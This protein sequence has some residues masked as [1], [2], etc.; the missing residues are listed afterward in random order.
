MNTEVTSLSPGNTTGQIPGTNTLLLGPTGVGKTYALRTA[1]A[2]GLEVFVLSTEPGI[3][4]TLGDIPSDK[5]HWKYVAPADTSWEDLIDSAQKINQLSFEALAKMSAI[6]KQ[7]YTQWIE[8]MYSLRNFIDDRT[9]KEFGDVTSWGPDRMLALDSLSGLNIMA[10][11]LVVGSKPT[12]SQA[13]WGVAMD[14]LKRFVHKLVSDTNCFFTLIGHMEREKDEISGAVKLMP[15]TLGRKLPAEIPLF[16]DDVIMAKRE[17]TS[18][19]WSTAATGADLKARNL[20][21]S[22]NLSPDFKLIVDE[23]KKMGGIL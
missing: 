8:V 4:S 12:K 9:G 15:A 6:N 5:L 21:I 3:A 17:G 14:N 22:D 11:N 1:V 19:K 20:P 2:A 23:W 13:D 18:F 10:M 16:F 7:K